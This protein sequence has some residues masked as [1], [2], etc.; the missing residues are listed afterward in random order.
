MELLVSSTSADP[1]V[2]CIQRCGTSPLYWK[3]ARGVSSAGAAKG[4]LEDHNTQ[5]QAVD[6]EGIL[7]GSLYFSKKGPRNP[8]MNN[9]FPTGNALLLLDQ[10]MPF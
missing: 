7:F 4:S 9:H 1:W 10:H 3:Q 2:C 8:E 5:Q 6:G